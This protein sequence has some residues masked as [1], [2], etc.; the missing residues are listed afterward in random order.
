VTT[1]PVTSTTVINTALSLALLASL[2][3]VG[4][5]E[6][7]DGIA[8]TDAGFKRCAGVYLGA[9][10]GI[11]KLKPRIVN[12][13]ET[14]DDTSGEV[15]PNLILGYDLNDHWSFEATYADQGEAGFASGASVDYA[16]WAISGLYYWP[17]NLPGLNAYAKAG[18][19]QLKTGVGQGRPDGGPF[20]VEQLNSTQLS[21]GLGGEYRFSNDWSLRA[22]ALFVDKDSSQLTLNLVKRFGR[23]YTPPA[24][25]PLPIPVAPPVEAPKILT[26]PECKELKTLFEQVYFAVD[27]AELTPASLNVLQKIA[28]TLKP[29]PLVALE[30]SAHTDAQGADAYNQALSERRAQSVV[31]YLN[32]QGT[33][34]LT[35]KGYGESRPVADNK[36]P[37]GRAQNRRV[38]M[39]ATGGKLCE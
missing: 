8:K 30:I 6:C 27:S 21:L 28:H 23:D 34:N 11:S 20:E 33:Q 37:T 2:P 18:L 16:H 9:G 25:A 26:A 22:E 17:S 10:L 38:E 31:A 35:A 14:L 29:F 36:T 3:A 7:T 15:V 4:L 32:N 39:A 12:L 1:K 19:G 5:A 24:P 13:P